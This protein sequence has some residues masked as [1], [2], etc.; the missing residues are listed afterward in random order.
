M[1][2]TSYMTT[3][4]SL[5]MEQ[6][7]DDFTK[8]DLKIYQYITDHKDTIA[9]VSLTELAESCQVAEATLLRFFRKMGYK[10]FQ[11]FKFSFAQELSN[12]QFSNPEDSV[13]EKI[14]NYMVTA[15][16]DS[17]KMIEQA[18][19]DAIVKSLTSAR[20]IV[21]F[22]VGAS[23][24]AALD[25]QN[26]LMRIGKH[27]EAI[28]DAHFQ[29]MRASTMD[30]DTVVVAISVSGSSK[31]IV[32]SV[33]LAKD[34]GATIVAITNYAKSPLTK[35]AD[36]VLVAA[37]KESPLDA[38]SLVA[39]VAQLYAVDLIC[40]ALALEDPEHVQ[41]IRTRISENTSSKLY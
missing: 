23:G 34:N 37:Y 14:K 2:P 16:E 28:T 12:E 31:D 27:V 29:I 15:L 39:K 8:S 33:Q 5:L 17:S 35:L 6:M 21:L 24:I 41:T 38:G 22:G 32:D 11:D 40:T 4:P 13:I 25:M 20:N 9:Y 1:V 36:D 30:A 10:G 26:R 19:L 18:T 7:K 3:K